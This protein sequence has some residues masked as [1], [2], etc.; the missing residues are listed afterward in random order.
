[1]RQRIL[2]L[3]ASCALATASGVRAETRHAAPRPAEQAAKQEAEDRALL[4]QIAEAQRGVGE[5]M[6]Q[7]QERMDELHGELARYQD[8]VSG[9]TDELKATRE[10]VKGLYVENT[11]LKEQ[12][13]AAKDAI[14]SVDANVS[15]FRTISGFFIAAMILLLVAIF[16][17]TVWR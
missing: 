6:Q 13:D 9:L 10:E 7:L 2:V 17:R 11:T 12:I 5:Q 4:Y 15:G 14:E 3:A 8:Q 16:A 1:M